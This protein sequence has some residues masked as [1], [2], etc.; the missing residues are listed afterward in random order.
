MSHWEMGRWFDVHSVN[1]AASAV[2]FSAQPHDYAGTKLG[3]VIRDH[4]RLFVYIFPISG[5]LELFELLGFE[6]IRI[7]LSRIFPRPNVFNVSLHS[8]PPE[9][10]YTVFPRF[11]P[12]LARDADL[13]HVLMEGPFNIGNERL[14]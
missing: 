5:G 11:P 4:A 12:D 10:P 8:Y 9:N 13:P 14:G 1:L 3:R 2:A 7:F 6:R